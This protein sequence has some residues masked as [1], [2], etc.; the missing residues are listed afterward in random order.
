MRNR[1]RNSEGKDTIKKFEEMLKNGESI[2]F[3]LNTFEYIINHFMEAGKLK[4]ALKACEVAMSQYPFSVELMLDKANLYI[5]KQKFD[6]ALELIEKAELFQPN[7]PDV[8]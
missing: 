1:Y 7:D 6:Q 4:K 5:R 2:F 8:I 3:D